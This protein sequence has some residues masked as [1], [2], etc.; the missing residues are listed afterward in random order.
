MT[1]PRGKLVVDVETDGL[2]AYLGARPFLLGAEDEAGEVVIADLTGASPRHSAP[3]LAARIRRAVEDPHV[4][5]VAHSAK[6]EIAMFKSLGWRPRG[7]WY[8]TMQMAPLHN[9]YEPSVS[10]KALA[11]KYHGS[12]HPEEQEIK[13]WLA[14]QNRIRRAEARADYRMHV[15]RPGRAPL[16]EAQKEELEA[17]LARVPTPTFK[18]FYVSGRANRDLM[19]SYLEK[20]LDDTLRLLWFYLPEMEDLY[21]PVFRVEMALPP[22]VQRME[23]AGLPVD[24][25]YAREKLDEYECAAAV[26]QDRMF[27]LAGE[28]FNP[29]SPPQ[30]LRVLNGNG[31]DVSDT[32]KETLG[33]RVSG[34][35]E[36]DLR[37]EHPLVDALL[38]FRA[39]V[40]V[41]D[42]FRALVDTQR[43]GLV[44]AQFWQNGQ[45][46][47][48]KTG[49]FSITN[50]GLQT[51]P[52]GYRGT[53]GQRGKDVRR[54][55]VPHRECGIYSLD[56]AQVE[57]RILVHYTQD[58]RLLEA[59]M[60]GRDIYAPFVELFFGLK[61][62][63]CDPE[64]WE[65][66]RSDAKTVI[67]AIMYGMGAARMAANLGVPVP[68]AKGLRKKCYRAIP[69]LDQC[70]RDSA[71]ELVQRG[72]VECLF[73]RRYRVP[74]DRS[75][76]AINCKIQ[77]AAAGV[78]KRA[79]IRADREMRNW[80]RGRAAAAKMLLTV[81]D[82]T[83]FSVPLGAD[84]ELVPVLMEAMTGCAPQLSVPLRVDVK[85]SPV[86]WGDKEK[87]AA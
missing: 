29:Q 28:R 35:A 59:L 50:P 15:G 44:H 5:K 85:W 58:E 74:Q 42:F 84:R 45:D 83:V 25:P 55:I 54:A 24:V 68:K 51:L 56:F 63:R 7:R 37:D 41:R 23:E 34:G 6:F 11:H 46:N 66:K 27:R 52:G 33:G 32:R 57:P 82:E 69:S 13:R 31:V 70:I 19:L 49:R 65:Q 39:N 2:S 76:V 26:Q 61:E 48:I 53:V 86:S 10:L 87:W 1:W 14:Q 9:E 30:L 12:E 64:V 47:A 71:K 40:K 43:G 16:T 17:A 8:D 3:A 73:G 22:V 81:H 4:T 60:S 75:Y 72:F 20:D 79:L 77:G 21:R 67:L 78:M 62:G 18:D 38:E 36:S 80:N